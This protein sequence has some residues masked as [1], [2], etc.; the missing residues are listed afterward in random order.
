MIDR[1]ER[2]RSNGL[3]V[4]DQTE[5]VFTIHRNAHRRAR[6][7]VTRL[8]FGV[9]HCSFTDRFTWHD[10]HSK[11]LHHET[12]TRQIDGSGAVPE[13]PTVVAGLDDVAMMGQIIEQPAV[14]FGSPNTLGHSPKAR[15]VVTI[16][17][18]RS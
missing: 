8:A 15:F 16:T 17:E 3:S 5:S 18:V 6:Q 13:P 14:I 9:R 10:F 11:A 7:T 2:S 12:W 1:I 4:Q